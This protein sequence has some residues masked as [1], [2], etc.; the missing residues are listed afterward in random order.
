MTLWWERKR[1]E[2]LQVFS[3]RSTSRA[4]RARRRNASLLLLIVTAFL[5]S[6]SGAEGPGYEG[7][8]GGSDGNG[9]VRCEDGAEEVCGK[10]LSQENG[11]LACLEGRRFCEGGAWTDCLGSE[12][13][14]R[15]DPKSDDYRG[16]FREHASPFAF[17]PPE[18]LPTRCDNNPCDPYC[19]F[20]DEDPT[21]ITANPPPPSGYPSFPGGPGTQACAHDMCDAG[22]PLYA[23]CSTCVADVCATMPSCCSTAWTSACV[24]LTYSLCAAERPP[25]YLCDFGVY[26]DTSISVRNNSSAN[27]VLGA[28]GDVTIEADGQV[29]GVYATGNITLNSLNGPLNAPYGLVADGSVTGQNA[30]YNMNTFIEAGGNVSIPAWRVQ[31][32]VKA[33]G[34]ISGMNSSQIL[35]NAQA[36]AG[37][38][39]VT[40]SGTSCTTAGCYTHKPVVLPPRTSGSAIPKFT[41]NCTGTTDFSANGTTVTVTAGPGVYRDVNVI[42]NGRIV[43]NGEG[44]YYFRNFNVSREVEFRRTAA[45]TGKG[46]DIRTC[47]NV[48]F[49]NDLRFMGSTAGGVTPVLAIDSTNSVVMNPALITF[50]AQTANTINIGTNAY[51]TGIFIAPNATVTKADVGG[52]PTAAA[53]NAG[54]RAAPV[55]GAIWAKQVNLGTGSLTKQIPRD[56]CVNLGIPGTGDAVPCTE[57]PLSLC[58]FGLFSSSTNQVTLDGLQATSDITVG[59]KGNITVSGNSGRNVRRI[60]TEGPVYLSSRDLPS[61]GILAG[62]AVTVNSPLANS[63]IGPIDGGADV[64]LYNFASVAGNVRA[65]GN[66]VWEA[67]IVGDALAGGTVN[68]NGGCAARVSGTCTSASTHAAP[69]ITL[70]TLPAQT[71]TCAGGTNYNTTNQTLAPGNYGD[72]VISGTLTLTTPGTYNF[73]RLYAKDILLQ[74]AGTRYNIQTCN[75]FNMYQDGR[76][77]QGAATVLTDPSRFFASVK[78]NLNFASNVTWV[79]VV[80]AASSGTKSGGSIRGAIWASPVND[81]NSQTSIT[82]ISRADCIA[83]AIPGTTPVCPG[84]CPIVNVTPAVPPAIKEPCG[85]GLDCQINNRCVGPQT[86]AACSHSKCMPG[87]ALNATCDTCVKRVCAVDSTCCTTGWTQSCVDKVATVCDAVCQPYSCYVADLCQPRAAPVAASCNSC[88][89]SICAV[90]PTCCSTSWTQAC[91]DKVYSVCGSG[92]PNSPTAGGSI[93]D[94][95]GYANGAASLQGTSGATTAKIYGGSVGGNGLG[96]MN[97]TYVYVDGHVFNAGSFYT[98]TTTIT[99]NLIYGSGSNSITATTYA[100]LI[101]GSPPQPSRPTRTISCPGGATPTSGTIAPGNYGAVSIPNGSTL[102]LQAGTYTFSSLNIGAT[103]GATAANRGTLALPAT[104]RVTINVCGAVNYNDFGRMT[105]VT[106]G[107]GGTAMNVDTYATGAIKLAPNAV[108]Y[109][110]M[111]STTDVRVETNATLYGFAWSGSTVNVQGNNATV[112]SRGLGDACR[113]THD[114]SNAPRRL[115]RLCGYAAYAKAGVTTSNGTQIRGGDLGSGTTV[116]VNDTSSFYTNVLAVGNVAKG[117]VS[118]LY[119][120]LRTRG[121]VSGSSPVYGG[122]TTGASATAVPIPSWPTISFACTSG[123]PPSG[124][125]QSLN[126][127]TLA[128]GTYGN[129]VMANDNQTLTLTAGNYYVGNLDLSRNGTILALPAAA[130]STVRIYACGKVTFGGTMTMTNPGSGASLG[131]FQVFSLATNSGDTDPAIYVNNGSGRSISGVMVAPNGKISVGPNSTLNGPAW[132]NAIFTGTTGIINSGTFSGASCEAIG[133]DANPTCPVSVTPNP[134]SEIADCQENNVGYKDTTC[135][136]FDLAAG[137]PCDNKVPVCNHGSTDFS[138]N[139]TIGYWASTAGQMSTEYP[140]R[141][142]EGTCSATGLNIVAGNC[143]DVTC[144]LP[145]TAAHT[146][147]LDSS[148]TVNECGTGYYDRRLDNWTVHDRRSCGGTGS[149]EVEYLYEAKCP[150]DSSALWGYLTWTTS[151][152]GSSSI[153]FSAANGYSAAALAS[154]TYTQVGVARLSPNTQAC[155]LAWPNAACAVPLSD[156]L[157]LGNV[158]GNFLALKM[159]LESLAGSPILRE[160]QVTYTCVYDQ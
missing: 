14:Y 74:G 159:K 42:N 128:P 78:G 141:T 137:I 44:T 113:T 115:D 153:T 49:G 83:M 86:A 119:R 112:D 27:A 95:A 62:G 57:D 155:T 54:T 12:V 25:L 80:Q 114:P 93:C 99:G 50:Y 36:N 7:G 13:T 68:L 77:L 121:T 70:P 145:G 30:S 111:N 89:S 73:T 75:E 138:G 4:S 43:L 101:N 41:T 46:W 91:A 139:L 6:C 29:A 107:V 38:T 8:Y 2:L 130:A 103:T 146:M 56:D 123:K 157:G 97:L 94:Y 23:T 124:A 150:A 160:W 136:T 19:W 40:V 135:A 147:L 45:N 148:N 47:G 106:G 100:A 151:T 158:Q 84:T 3:D 63:P 35:G 59:G 72:V 143:V 154:P 1:C 58:D 144:V 20:Y 126:S 102:T 120:S 9:S 15:P 92:L 5:I 118:Q 81:I 67:N 105:G 11:V 133:V 104:G 65:R 117:T 61:A 60:I 109:G 96:S 82:G 98:Y 156:A 142:P 134:P 140:T 132:G 129:V 149:K 55:N 116:T 131:K 32:Y 87:A 125:D 48:S 24:N 85:S 127:S 71:F 26:S 39:G 64:S 110:I 16:F 33:G 37:I 51:I 76:V 152:P 88:V 17:L 90:D 18:S 66:L 52:G 10:V 53:V 79:G 108:A 22:G 31:Q 28:Y 122:Q 21:D 69:A 34:S